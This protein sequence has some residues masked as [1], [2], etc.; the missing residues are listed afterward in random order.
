MKKK[1]LIFGLLVACFMLAVVYLI[2]QRSQASTSGCRT[3]NSRTCSS[4]S[5]KTPDGHTIEWSVS[6]QR[7]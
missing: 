4:G 6:G 3:N 5:F 7:N 2:P 1:T